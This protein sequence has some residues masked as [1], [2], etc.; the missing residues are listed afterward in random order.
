MAWTEEEH[1]NFLIGLQKLG[2]GDWRGISRHFVTTR[3]PT[4]VASHAQ[5]YFIRQTNVSKRKRRSSLFDIVAEPTENGDEHTIVHRSTADTANASTHTKA[6]GARATNGVHKKTQHHTGGMYVNPRES[7]NATRSV[8]VQQHRATGSALTTS[9]SNLADAASREAHYVASHHITPPVGAIWMHN[10][11]ARAQNQQEMGT[12]AAIKID[13]EVHPTF[14][15]MYGFGTP[16]NA[17]NQAMVQYMAQ[18][19]AFAPHMEGGE[20]GQLSHINQ[21]NQMAWMAQQN[22]AYQ[23]AARSYVAQ[24]QQG[25]QNMNF[26]RPTAIYATKATQAKMNSQNIAASGAS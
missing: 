18:L 14:P 17:Y 1:K 8:D 4:Q 2:K 12:S 26:R 25:A 23:M 13:E 16:V 6:V 24:A 20:I 11:T 7:T 21:M 22:M 3:T 15:M 19:Q 5:K 10:A 9:L